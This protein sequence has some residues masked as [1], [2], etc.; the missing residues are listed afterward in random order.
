MIGRG[1]TLGRNIVTRRRRK[2]EISNLIVFSCMTRSRSSLACRRRNS[3]HWRLKRSSVR[4]TNRLRSSRNR[5]K[6]TCRIRSGRSRGKISLIVLGCGVWA[7]ACK[8]NARLV[9]LCKRRGE[10]LLWLLTRLMVL[11]TTLGRVAPWQK[12]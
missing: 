5:R 1:P 2:V 12:G 3:R 9:F 6:I 10:S 8:R 7:I 11:D 4:L